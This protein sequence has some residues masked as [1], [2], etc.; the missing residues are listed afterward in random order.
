MPAALRVVLP[1]VPGDSDKVLTRGACGQGEQRGVAAVL[2]GDCWGGTPVGGQESCICLPRQVWQLAS[3]RDQTLLGRG[4]GYPSPHGTWQPSCCHHWSFP[5]TWSWSQS[6]C[7]PCE[8]H[9]HPAWAAALCWLPGDMLALVGGG[10]P[11]TSQSH[12]CPTPPPAWG[13][14]RSPIHVPGHLVT[15]ALPWLVLPLAVCGHYLRP[16]HHLA[17]GLCLLCG[18]CL[19]LL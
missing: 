2:S 15:M 12:A 16:D 4:Q 14:S 18:A 10:E 13:P 6:C 1:A 3:R 8:L 19:H 9:R 5:C 17:P 7:W 11:Y